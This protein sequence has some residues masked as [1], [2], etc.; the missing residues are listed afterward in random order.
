M[1]SNTK[2]IYAATQSGRI[3][4]IGRLLPMQQRVDAANR[5]HAMPAWTVCPT[6]PAVANS[7][8]RGN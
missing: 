8:R 5:E 3:M 6:S 7:L 2:R 4:A 1:A